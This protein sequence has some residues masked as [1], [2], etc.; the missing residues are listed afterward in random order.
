MKMVIKMEKSNQ[1]KKQ[2]FRITPKNAPYVF[3]APGI[4]LF[5]VFGAYPI[6]ASLIYSFQQK[7]GSRPVI[8]VGLS[9]Y[10]RAFSDKIFLTSLWNMVIIFIMHAPLMI[11]LSLLL[12]YVLNSRRTRFKNGF[13]TAFFLPNVTNAVAYTVLF[14]ILFANNGT[15]NAILGYLGV[16]PVQWLSSATTA[17]WVIAIMNIWRWTGYN[18]VILLA[19]MQ[20]ISED[21]YEA[22]DID[23]ASKT[24]QFFSITVPLMKNPLYFTTI[25]TINGTLTMFT[26]SQ[27]LLNGG[28]SFGTYTPSLYIYNVAW[29]Q[30][31][32]G[33][34][35][36]MGYI[37]SI[38]TIIIAFIQFRAGKGDK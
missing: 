9:N 32:F 12:A 7:M 30:F 1:R 26:E 16:M 38:I 27:L 15:L 19:A 2:R 4:I 25:M 36:A 18:M 28:P 29:Q 6:F 34:S 3:M 31:N 17:Q 14:K 37:I 33:Y 10:A 20:N 11:F 8:F 24:R 5:A 13:R 23:G 35:S 21:V 22:A